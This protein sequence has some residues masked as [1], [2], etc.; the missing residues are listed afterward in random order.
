MSLVDSIKN[1]GLSDKEARVYLALLQFEKATAYAVALKSGLKKPTTYVILNDLVGKGF[2]LKEPYATKQK[3]IAVSPEKCVAIAREKLSETEDDLPSLLALKKEPE[4]KVS[5]EYYEGLDG[6][7]RMYRNMLDAKKNQEI[8]SFTGH[9]RD[10]SKELIDFWE[11]FNK[12]RVEKNISA[13]GITP[14]DETT[15]RWTKNQQRFLLNLKPIPL[16]EYDSNVSVEIFNNFVQI[17]SFGQLQGVRID[18]ADIYKA[19]KQLFNMYWRLLN[20]Q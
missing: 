7:K 18:N 9:G 3:Y 14:Q 1:L 17:V 10:V 12:E 11:E 5:V 15:Q 4:K 2:V 6:I 19:F 16:K 8:L 13:R 20:K